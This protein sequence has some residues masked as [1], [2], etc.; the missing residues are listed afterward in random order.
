MIAFVLG[1]KA[2]LIKTM[3]I[4]KE[5]EKKGIEYYFIH[6]GQHLI[7]DLIKDFRIKG[8]DITLYTPPKLSS[9]FMTKTHK[10]IF[11][12]LDG[13][14]KISKE[15]RKIKPEFVC[16][17]G[18]TLSTTMAAIASSNI[19]NKNKKWKNAHLEAGLR[20]N[21]IFEPFPEEISRRIA[22]RFSD[23]LFAVSKGAVKNLKKEKLGGK[24][25]NVG[26]TIVDAALLSLKIANK[27]FGKLKEKNF[28]LIN[29]HR[30][31]NIKSK[32]RLEKIVNIIS[33]VN[34]PAYW[35]LHDNTKQQLIK[36]G[37]MKKIE[38]KKNIKISKLLS[39]LKFI[40]LLANCKYLITDGGSIQEESLAFKKP[41]ILLRVKTE[42]D[43]GLKTGINFLTKLDVEYSKKL[44]QEIEN[45][46]LKIAKFK[47]PYGDG[48]ASKRIVNYLLNL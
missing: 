42:R 21:D 22:D 4:M 25:V 27:K 23:I 34:I 2:E 10:A 43:E 29:I 14:L 44:I 41:C 13:I 33:N 20:S 28:C 12:G 48:K 15:I 46:K 39:Y 5:L 36:F 17:H 37:L 1:T 9:R 26:N 18:D 16:Y 30:H 40:R 6:T 32:E 8:P 24:I 19:L 38:K 45:E 47:N 35:P 7:T 3:P 11:W 31:E